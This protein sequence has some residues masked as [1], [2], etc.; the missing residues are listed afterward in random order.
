MLIS[1]GPLR[2]VRTTDSEGFM[3]SFIASSYLDEGRAT[4]GSH[5]W[6]K[7]TGMKVPRAA[8]VSAPP[9]CYIRMGS[10]W[11]QGGYGPCL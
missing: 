4:S 7:T 11:L 3:P 1:R 6:R 5:V 8:S 10:L 9:S 2:F